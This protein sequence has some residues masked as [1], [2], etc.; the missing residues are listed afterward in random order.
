MLKGWLGILKELQHAHAN[1]M[2]DLSGM[3]DKGSWPQ[4]FTLLK[5]SFSTHGVCLLSVVSWAS[6]ARLVDPSLNPR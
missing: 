6:E 4:K 1:E 2:M 5:L 3:C